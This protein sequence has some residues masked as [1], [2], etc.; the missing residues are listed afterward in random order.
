MTSRL[1]LA[2]AVAGA[3]TL[4]AAA[5]A[6]TYCVDDPSCSGIAQPTL[7]AALDAAKATG[8]ADTIRIG[9]TPAPLVG[10]FDSISSNKV[11]VVGAGA[12]QTVLAPG[13]ASDETLRLW[14]PSSEVRDLTVR[15]KD[16]AGAV[17]L[18]T[19]ATVEDVRVEHTGAASDVTGVLVV[20]GGTLRRV[21]VDLEQGRG[22]WVMPNEAT[23]VEDSAIRA[24]AAGVEALADTVLTVRRSTISSRHEAIAAHGQ[25][26]VEDV[27]ARMTAPAAGEAAVHTRPGGQLEGRHLTVIAHGGAGVGATST[28]AGSAHVVLVN[29]VITGATHSLRRNHSGG[30]VADIL[31]GTTRYDTLSTVGGPGNGSITLAAGTTQAPVT[32]VDPDAGDYRLRGAS[33]G[34]D[35][36]SEPASTAADRLGRPRVGAPDLG[37]FEHQDQAPTAV[38]AAPATAAPGQGIT[39]DALG[40][41]D[42][43]GDTFDVA[44][45]FTDGTVS[46]EPVV[47]R[48]FAAAGPQVATLTLTD[49]R[50]RTATA[51]ATVLVGTPGGGGGGGGGGGDT[52][53]S[54][55]A[56]DPSTEPGTAPNGPS[57]PADRPAADRTAPTLRL[58]A[59]PRRPR[60]DSARRVRL[61]LSEP[62]QVRAH[63][64]RRV[65]GRWVLV[66]RTRTLALPAGTSRVALN[67]LGLTRPGRA[68][69]TLVATDAEGNAGPPATARLRLRPPR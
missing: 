35:A 6:A 66:V 52:A 37:A 46:D 28:A 15:V 5:S 69:V 33:T 68:R 26:Q 23:V 21:T 61:K 65:K 51:A 63:L 40:S 49:E 13:A 34:I 7:Q 54:G 53:P 50:G 56:S 22:V 31:V 57:E 16:D 14:G 36:G 42:P 10:P 58:V 45:S 1:P 64:A 27:V 60:A 3:L 38:I 2:L 24:P 43:D 41:S 59:V 44:W 18:S 12:G 39:F 29:S 25:A 20:D 9:P 11:T 19:D 48:S 62:A 32:F 17:G 47:T 55:P 67:D 4:P 8:A 30:T